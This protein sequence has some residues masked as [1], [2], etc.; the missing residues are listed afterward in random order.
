VQSI[1]KAAIAG[2][3]IPGSKETYGLFAAEAIAEADASIDIKQIKGCVPY[4][5]L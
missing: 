1:S 5:K 3:C 4:V 2:V